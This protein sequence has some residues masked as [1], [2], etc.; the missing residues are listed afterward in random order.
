MNIKEAKK[1]IKNTLIAYLSR[2][3]NGSYEIPAEHRRPVFLLG[4]PGIGKSAIMRQISEELRIGLV[5]YSMTHHTR[6]S[7][8]GLPFIEDRIYNG[9]EYKVTEYTMSEIISSV[10]EEMERSGCTEGILFLDEVN[11]VSETL[12]PSMLQ[13]LQYKTFGRHQIPEGWLIV[14]AGNPPEYNDSVRDFDI[15]TMDRLKMIDVEPD[16]EIWKEYAYERS[17]HPSIITYLETKQDHFYKVESTPKGK[18]FVTARGWEDLSKIIRVYEKEGVEVDHYLMEQY[19]HNENISREFAAYYRLYCKYRSDYRIPDILAG[20]ASDEIK[21]RARKS[22]FDERFAL[23][24]L[25]IDMLTE[26][27]KKVRSM[28]ESLEKAGKAASGEDPEAAAAHLSDRI[29]M[30]FSFCEEVF[31]DG[32]ELLILVTELTVNKY[33][34]EF[35]GTYGCKKYYEHNRDLL[36][37]ER[38]QEI[39]KR[40]SLLDI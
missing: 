13:F 24:G 8:I 40:L 22:S 35:I 36:F 37:Y 14:T 4:A 6:Q 30:L 10:Y 9:K 7:A 39:E 18:S 11:C 29:D 16:F 19:L 1:Q 2:D 23:L 5:S 26:D 28:E 20:N 38:D 27:A 12:S 31:P 25:C 33:I 21:A 32:Q 3:E 15:A 17:I 34:A